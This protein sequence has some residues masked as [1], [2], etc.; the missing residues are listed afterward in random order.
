MTDINDDMLPTDKQEHVYNSADALREVVDVLIA[1]TK[2]GQLSWCPCSGQRSYVCMDSRTDIPVLYLFSFTGK[3][4]EYLRWEGQ[5][6]WHGFRFSKSSSTGVVDQDQELE[7]AIKAN[8]RK[9]LCPA[10]DSVEYFLQ[11]RDGL[12]RVGKVG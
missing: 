5:K 6:Y 11:I 10:G 4:W 2:T 1:Q 12:Q 3:S 7:D 9:G 8:L